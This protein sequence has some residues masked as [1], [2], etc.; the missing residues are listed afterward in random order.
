MPAATPYVLGRTQRFWLAVESTFGTYVYPAAQTTTNREIRVPRS[1]LG[2]KI[3][4]DIRS[5]ARSTRSRLEHVTGKTTNQCEIEAYL[6]GS[7]TA[8]TP[9]NIHAILLAA[10][11][12]TTGYT[13]TPAT[14]DV[15]ALGDL[16]GALPSL[17]F[18]RHFGDGALAGVYQDQGA[19]W[20]INELRISA[21]GGEQ[22]KIVA[23]G[24]FKTHKH[25]GYSTVA[26]N[27][28]TTVTVQTADANN[29]EL[30]DVLE[31][32][33]DDGTD[34]LGYYVSV[35]AGAVLTLVNVSGGGPPSFGTLTGDPVRPHLPSGSTTG[36][37]ISGNLG[38]LSLTPSG[39]SA[40]AGGALPITAFELTLNNNLKVID[41][42]LF[43]AEI[44]D[45]IPGHRELT[46]SMSFRCRRDLLVI[47]GQRKALTAHDIVATFGS[48][49]GSR[50]LV[51]VKAE[52]DFSDMDV[53]EVG[54][55]DAAEA[56][57]SVPFRGLATSAANELTLSYT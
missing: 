12:G 1:V 23:S 11:G 49:A 30:G 28:A 2:T 53:P 51:T 33:G 29:F 18:A 26:S 57:V 55:T 46:G 34:D 24:P 44:S 8:G 6:L 56:V 43:A 50:C 27:T 10:M 39:G 22:P 37:P 21:S 3:Q 13:N 20:L 54:D 42:E 14:S 7:G 40:Y 5:D 41:D 19:G 15:Y 16:Q 48:V 25:A 4:R 38:S 35:K 47:L 9:P 36:S 52:L 32:D 45:A 31:I 17:S